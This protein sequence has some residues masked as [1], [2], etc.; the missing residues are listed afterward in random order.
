MQHFSW[1]ANLQAFE[2]VAG[3]ARVAIGDALK[4]TDQD[5]FAFAWI[6]DF[7]MYEGR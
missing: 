3:K 1:A 5:R 4:L 6:V 2:K 7:P